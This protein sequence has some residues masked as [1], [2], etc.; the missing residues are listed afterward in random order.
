MKQYESLCVMPGGMSGFKRFGLPGGAAA[1][2]VA[3][4]LTVQAEPV[5]GLERL[6]TT[7]LE[8]QQ[9]DL[10]RQRFLTGTEAAGEAVVVEIPAR[11][12]DIHFQAALFPANEPAVLWI[13]GRKG[14]L[15]QWRKDR[16]R[17]AVQQLWLEGQGS[18]AQLKVQLDNRLYR[19]Q[20]NDILN[21][22]SHRVTPAYAYVPVPDE[23][24]PSLIGTLEQQSTRT[25]SGQP[26]ST[27]NALTD[28]ALQLRQHNDNLD[29]LLKQ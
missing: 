13:N 26:G 10:E 29:Q 2:T 24:I 27:G 8:R 21:R 4:S 12:P 1:L 20:L 19:L 9:I 7:V 5:A 3:L 16:D 28:K 11:D 6:F 17:L 23:Q 14:S 25:V 18:D 22:Y 15:A